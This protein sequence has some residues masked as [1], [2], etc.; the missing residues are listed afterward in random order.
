MIKLICSPVLVI[1]AG[2]VV[3]TGCGQKADVTSQLQKAESELA[4]SEPAA[5]AQPQSPPISQPNQPAA[6]APEASATATPSQQMKEAMVAYKAGNLE[7]AVIRL[8][9]LR[10]TPTM[11]AQQRIALNDA[12][13]AVMTEIYTMASKGD[14]R[15]VA[16]VK[17]YEF[18]Q[19]HRQ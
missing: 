18:L 19:T 9:K 11:N 17:Q 2:V 6:P 1:L 10:A 8:Q 14:G 12:M 3:L 15:A 16:A 4:K 5:A 7:D 13:A